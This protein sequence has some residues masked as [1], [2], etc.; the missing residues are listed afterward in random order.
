MVGWHH[1]LNGHE[2]EQTPGDSEGQGT[3]AYC[4]PWGRKESDTTDG[5]KNNNRCVVVSHSYF[6]LKTYAFY[7]LK[8]WAK[9]LTKGDIQCQIFLI[10]SLLY[11]QSSLQEEKKDVLAE[12][13]FDPSTSGLW[14]Q[15]AS[16]APLC[17]GSALC[18]KNHIERSLN[19]SHP[20]FFTQRSL[21]SAK[22]S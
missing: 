3:L 14:A 9:H 16:A 8:K 20:N 18:P 5:L 1:R 15:H 10:N 17:C 22:G 19:A 2:F 6:V 7:V 12:D 11:S 13:G 4:D 21:V